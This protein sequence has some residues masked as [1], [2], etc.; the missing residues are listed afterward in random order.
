[1]NAYLWIKL[2]HILS[3]TILFG[4]GIGTAFFMLKTYLSNDDQAMAVTTRNV[5]IA[6]W[7]FTTPAVVVQLASGIWL[8]AKLGIPFD[9]KWFVTVISLFVFVGICWLPV[10]RIQIRIRNLI[11]TG[12]G[13]D[14]YAGL[15]KVWLAL[16]VPAFLS[17]L[18][19]F[20]LMVSK[21]GAY[22]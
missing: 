10:V 21:T 9:S 20:Y 1:V 4:T 14:A 18:I 2:I 22:A 13:R 12:A 15:M 5:V 3:A 6:D 7:L 16:G 11:K 8:T 19:L 17:V